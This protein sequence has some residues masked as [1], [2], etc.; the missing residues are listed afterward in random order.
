VKGRGEWRDSTA[1]LWKQAG[2]D[3]ADARRTAS[4]VTRPRAW[5]H[6]NGIRGSNPPRSRVESR[7]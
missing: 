2:F 6:R 7:R 5:T 1:G 3:G 4:G